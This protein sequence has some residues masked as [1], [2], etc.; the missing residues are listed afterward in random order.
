MMIKNLPIKDISIIIPTYNEESS[1]KRT[2]FS[3]IEYFKDKNINYEIIVS[4]DGS[5]DRT[6]DIVS[7]LIKKQQNIILLKNEN[8]GKGGAV[9][10]GILKASKKYCLFM[11]ADSSTN[12]NEIEKFSKHMINVDFIIGSRAIQQNNKSKFLV[13]RKIVGRIF[14]VLVLLFT[15]LKFK[16]T[17]CGFKFIVTNKA[18][19]IFGNLQEQGFLFDVEILL[20]A[21]INNMKIKEVGIT[22]QE[23]I[24]KSKV[25]IIKDSFNMF[26]GLLMLKK[27]MNYYEKNNL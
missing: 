8:T 14:N 20:L 7:N 5:I 9:K 4:D 3:I 26:I 15:G 12:I 19:N 2:I 23:S 22:W 13:H 18:K 24:Y 27:K 16:D 11:D 17:Q 10:R 1:I 25:N 21:K 6:K